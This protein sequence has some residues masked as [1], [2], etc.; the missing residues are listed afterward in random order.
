MQKLLR[1]AEGA[2][3][4][5]YSLLSRLS[6]FGDVV[7]GDIPVRVSVVAHGDLCATGLGQRD[8]FLDRGV[9]TALE[10]AKCGVH[11]VQLTSPEANYRIA[12][13]GRNGAENYFRGLGIAHVG[14]RIGQIQGL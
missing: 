4:F 13:S 6:G 3:Q 8:S 5:T 2:S 1:S 12:Q 11:I 14:I 9:G 10:V 7:L